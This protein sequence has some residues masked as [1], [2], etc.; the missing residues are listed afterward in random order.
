[1]MEKYTQYAVKVELIY[2]KMHYPAEIPVKL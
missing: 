2:K 1:M